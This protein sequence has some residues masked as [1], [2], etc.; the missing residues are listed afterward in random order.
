[1]HLITDTYLPDYLQQIWSLATSVDTFLQHTKELSF[2]YLIET[3]SLYS[4][5]IEGNPLDL[6]SFMNAKMNSQK[7]KEFAE[8]E[9]LIQAY[10]FARTH[11]LNEK[12]LLH[13]HLLLSKTLLDENQQGKRR[14]ERVW[15]FGNEGLV[16][17]AIEPQFVAEKMTELF[18]DIAEL[19][20]KKLSVEECFY[21]ASYV[22]L[23]FA[24]LHPFPDGNG[25][26][27]RLLEKWFLTKKLWPEFRKL[28][29]E[30][31]YKEHRPEYYNNINL[32]INYYELNY[33]KAVPFLLMLPQ[34][35]HR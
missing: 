1:M 19:L 13:I 3:S 12:N 23:V 25:R 7:P 22:H 17:L 33:A 24:H 27:A 16:Y 35:L 14:N 26:S 2:E 9:N 21:Y 11:P 28:E 5:N 20:E 29:A 31:Y 32:W 15:V 4:S 34:S 10:D 30:K 18:A 8:I 6:N